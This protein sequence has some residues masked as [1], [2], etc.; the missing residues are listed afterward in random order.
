MGRLEP[1]V[2]LHDHHTRRILSQIEVGKRVSQRSLA[3]ELGIALGL[4]NSLIRKLVKKGWVK[5]ISVKPNRVRYL[6][7]RAGIAGKARIT[8]S[9]LNNTVRLYTETRDRI[10]ERL[11][12]LSNE[13][14]GGPALNGGKRI[15]FYG[16]GDV[17]EIGYICLQGT[18]LHLVGVVDDRRTE[19]FFGIPVNSPDCVRVSGLNGKQ[20]DRLVVMSFRQA[21]RIRARLESVAFP[22]DKVFWI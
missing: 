18:D 1:I 4:T 13:C 19:P 22:A 10:R 8:R 2:P 7:T 6:I 20:F 12:T 21:D 9:Y 17:A 11:T 14:P 5:A 3:K 16:A 15:V